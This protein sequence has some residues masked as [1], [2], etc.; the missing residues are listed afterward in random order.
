MAWDVSTV[1]I[2][3]STKKSRWDKAVDNFKELRSGSITIWGG[4]TFS[5]TVAFKNAVTFKTST[6]FT[7]TATFAKYP[8]ASGLASKNTFGASVERSYKS[9][10]T[11]LKAHVYQK[12]FRL[13]SW[14]MDTVSQVNITSGIASMQTKIVGIQCFIMDDGLTIV[15]ELARG[16]YYNFNPD[17][18]L[19]ILRDAGGTFDSTLYN[20]TS[21]NRGWVIVDY[22]L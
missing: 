9:G 17:G 19:E 12:V 2:G 18:T 3:E 1:T 5:G 14:D 13:G 11:D 16:G 15:S 4:K 8:K 10:S 7:G 22:I 20:D 6:V 21:V